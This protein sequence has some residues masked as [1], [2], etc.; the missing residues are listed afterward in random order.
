M[1]TQSNRTEPP[2]TG[3]RPRREEMALVTRLRLPAWVTLAAR[4]RTAIE[5]I[6]ASA[7]HQMVS[8][9]PRE[10]LKTASAAAAPL[11]KADRGPAK[12]GSRNTAE[13]AI[14]SPTD[15]HG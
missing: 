2:T 10:V 15:S 1:R 7:V 4:P 13:S 12:Y 11:T 8:M 6:A 3:A 9:P 5:T 14:P